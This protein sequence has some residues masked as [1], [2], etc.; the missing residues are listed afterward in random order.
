MDTAFSVQSGEASI[1]LVIRDHDGQVVL[2]AWK[3]LQMCLS[4]EEAEATACLEGV[5]LAVEWIGK[6]TV[7]FSDCFYIVK[8]LQDRMVDTTRYSS[9]INEIKTS[10]ML[11]PKVKV[12]KIG[13]ECNRVAHE[14]ARLA[15]AHGALCGL[16]IISSILY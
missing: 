12:S 16:E 2:T 1:G 7:R 10:M 8:A 3:V 11:L 9:I 15:R 5:Q 14:L 13:R 4:V 6:P